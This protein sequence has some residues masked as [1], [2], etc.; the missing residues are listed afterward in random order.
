MFDLDFIWQL[1]EGTLSPHLFQ[2]YGGRHEDA[3][4]P[5]GISAPH[6]I[7]HC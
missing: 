3:S 5:L 1:E 6:D 7:A 4:I 2:A